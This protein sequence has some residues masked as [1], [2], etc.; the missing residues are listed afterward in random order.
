VLIAGSTAGYAL[1]GPAILIGVL[2][3]RGE[4]GGKTT[5]LILPGAALAVGV[6]SFLV[7]NSPVLTGLG[8][9]DFGSTGTMSRNDLYARTIKAIIDFLPLGSGLGSF[10]QL[11]PHYEDPD[12]VTST[13]ANH[14]HSDYLE[15]VLELGLPGAAILVALVAWWVIRS[16]QIWTTEGTEDGRLQRAA[17]IAVGLIIVHSIVDYPLRTAAAATFT[18]MCLALMAGSPSPPRKTIRKHEAPQRQHVDI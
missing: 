3:F 10:E 9:T 11:F 18:A 14:A 4:E 12:L 17:S 1:L 5:A 6:M 8:V 2:I 13:F 15:F 7:A 16:V